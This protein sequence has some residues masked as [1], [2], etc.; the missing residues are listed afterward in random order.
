MLKHT[1]LAVIV[2]ALF[3]IPMVVASQ[4]VKHAP[5]LKSCSADI[6]LW[7]SEIPLGESAEQLEA[8]TKSL[9]AREIAVREKALS[10]CQIAHP[11][12]GWPEVNTLQ[13]VYDMLLIERYSVFVARHGMYDKFI[14]EDEAGM[15]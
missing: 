5:T 12:R 6:R 15:R 10:D 2:V 4:E 8:A 3:A 1:Q 14:E 13:T 7:S 9:T 11:E